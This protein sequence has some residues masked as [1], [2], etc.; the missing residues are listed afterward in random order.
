MTKIFKISPGQLAQLVQGLVRY[1]L[2]VSEIFKSHGRTWETC[3]ERQ[4]ALGFVDWFVWTLP[5]LETAWERMP[6]GLRG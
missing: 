6:Q 1:A 5:S 4:G 3:T 2:S